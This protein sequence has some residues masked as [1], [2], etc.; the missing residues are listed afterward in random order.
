MGGNEMLV[1][2]VQKKMCELYFIDGKSMRSIAEELKLHRKT[3]KNYVSD[4]EKLLTEKGIQNEPQLI[5]EEIALQCKLES[6]NSKKLTPAFI[7][8]VGGKMAASEKKNRVD[9]YKE[10]RN[11]YDIIK[12]GDKNVEVN[13]NVG[14]STF[15]KA[16]EMYNRSAT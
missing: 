9:V 1:P 11:S 8:F 7:E 10:I 2:D 3:I 6:L 4:M 15:C 14:Y 5:G 16:V 13:C 12:V